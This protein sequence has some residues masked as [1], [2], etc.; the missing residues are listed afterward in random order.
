MLTVLVD[1]TGSFTQQT[2]NLTL[3]QILLRLSESFLLHYNSLS[4]DSLTFREH[5]DPFDIHFNLYQAVN[6]SLGTAPV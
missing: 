2:V 6:S 5:L 4:S 1:G 3:S